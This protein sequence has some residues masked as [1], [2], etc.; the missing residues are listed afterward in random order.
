MRRSRATFSSISA[1]LAAALARTSPQGRS[2]PARSASNSLI[3]ARVNP[4]SLARWMNRRRFT[5]CPSY[6]R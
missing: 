2:D 5:A 1:I 6:S 4:M 3:S